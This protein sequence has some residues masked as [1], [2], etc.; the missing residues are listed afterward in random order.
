M[1]VTIWKHKK[2]Y[3]HRMVAFAFIWEVD[4]LQ[5]CHKDDNPNNN[6]ANNL[7]IWTIQDNIDDKI[8]KWRHV[9]WWKPISQYTLSGK[10]IKDWEWWAWEINRELWFDDTWIYNCCHWKF[11]TSKWFIWKFKKKLIK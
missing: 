2:E 7:F 11:S 3:V 5:V 10:H 6:N 8:T 1:K 9:I 4:W